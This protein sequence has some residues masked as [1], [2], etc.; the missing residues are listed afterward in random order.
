M[1]YT[2]ITCGIYAVCSTWDCDIHA[3]SIKTNIRISGEICIVHGSIYA[4]LPY[5]II[6]YMCSKTQLDCKPAA[7][8]QPVMQKHSIYALVCV[9]YSSIYAIVSM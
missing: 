5:N 1:L 7:Y 8:M 3:I 2:L 9:I 4:V 6:A